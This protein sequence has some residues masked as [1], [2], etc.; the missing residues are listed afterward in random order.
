M[1]QNYLA[2]TNSYSWKITKPLRFLTKYARWFI[3][4]SYHW[5]TFSPTSRPRRVLQ[6]KL[7]V[8]KTY[9]NKRPRLKSKIL[10]VLN[11]LPKLKKAIQSASFSSH[12]LH[13]SD[14]ADLSQ[15]TKKIYQN[16]HYHIEQKKA[17]K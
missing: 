11:Y 9:I 4:G 2:I 12:T 17:S 10:T 15:Q 14:S 7:I 5:L 13:S 1:Q 16:L 3:T 6:N 8:I